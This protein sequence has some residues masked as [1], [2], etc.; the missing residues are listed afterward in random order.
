L[1]L[2]KGTAVDFLGPLRLSSLGPWI[3]GLLNDRV[4]WIGGIGVIGC[5]RRRAK[6]Q[7]QGND[8]CDHEFFLLSGTAI[9]PATVELENKKN[10]A[11]AGRFSSE[12]AMLGKLRQ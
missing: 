6:Q 10:L 1:C 11:R 7:G 4:G 3:G 12:A 5:S 8:P 9:S 2:G